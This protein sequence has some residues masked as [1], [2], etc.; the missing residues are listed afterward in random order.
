VFIQEKVKEPSAPPTKP[1]PSQVATFEFPAIPNTLSLVQSDYDL[2]ANDGVPALMR[3]KSLLQ[4]LGAHKV[5]PCWGVGHIQH[6]QLPD[7]LSL[8]QMT[9]NRTT[10]RQNV[11]R[12]PITTTA[13]KPTASVG[14]PGSVL[15]MMKI[16]LMAGSPTTGSFETP[17]GKIDVVPSSV[18]C[19]EPHSADGRVTKKTAKEYVELVSEMQAVNILR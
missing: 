4:S 19:E 18:V 1:F 11:P 8:S 5:S 3:T 12:D 9:D 13:T 17:K 10:M 14:V 15:A 2:E 16:G 7:V 6:I